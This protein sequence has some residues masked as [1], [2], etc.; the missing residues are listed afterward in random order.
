MNLSSIMKRAIRLTLFIIPLAIFGNIIYTLLT[1]EGQSILSIFELH[2]GWLLLAVAFSLTPW[3]FSLARLKMWNRFFKL[4]LRKRDMLEAILANEVAALTTP[5]A[6][7]GGYA[8]I[9]ML[10]LRGVSPGLATS[11]MVIGSIED[12]LFIIFLVP[13]LW[14]L[15]PPGN[16]QL[17]EIIQRHLPSAANYPIYLGIFAAISLIV[18]ITFL[19]P[20]PRLYLAKFF[21]LKWWHSRVLSPLLKAIIDFKTAFVLISRGGKRILIMN[22]VLATIQWIM[23]Y[24]VFTAIAYGLGF[25]PNII[26]FFL[27]QWLV[28]MLINIVPTPGAIGGAEVVFTYVFRAFVPA[29]QIAIAANYWRFIA[30]YMQLMVAALILMMYERPD[31]HLPHKHSGSDAESDEE[32]LPVTEVHNI[33]DVKI[34]TRPRTPV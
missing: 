7:G 13:I 4:N 11:L 25:S 22:S 33:P 32:N 34:K 6:I 31:I 1:N 14:Y 2:P 12:Y 23:R 3:I 9:G 26:E 30:T 17:F 10:I 24:S 15:Y 5:T 19:F 16:I 8:K 20:A 27:L 21:E 18:G 28:F 29:G